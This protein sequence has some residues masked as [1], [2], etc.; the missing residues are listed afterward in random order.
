MLMPPLYSPSGRRARI[1]TGSGPL[2]ACS[3]QKSRNVTQIFGRA[4]SRNVEDS[5]LSY[6]SLHGRFKLD[7]H[8]FQICYSTMELLERELFDELEGILEAVAAGSGCIVLASGEAGIEKKT[9][10]EGFAERHNTRARVFCGAC[11]ALFTPRPLGPLYDIAPQTQGELLTLLEQQAPRPEPARWQPFLIYQKHIYFYR[12]LHRDVPV[13]AAKI[14]SKVEPPDQLYSPA[15][16]VSPLLVH[17][18][19][20]NTRNFGV[21]STVCPAEAA[22]SASEGSFAITFR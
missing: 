6:R 2:P 9:L 21:R 20:S 4:N 11:D 17:S 14:P 16:R 12:F 18:L 10:V 8:R 15:R 7:R 22:P 13:H 3:D 19:F 1:D 5:E